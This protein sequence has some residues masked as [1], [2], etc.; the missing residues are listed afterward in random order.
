MTRTAFHSVECFKPD[1]TLLPVFLCELQKY[2]SPYSVQTQEHFM[3]LSEKNGEFTR[4]STQHQQK[5]HN[6]AE[7]ATEQGREEPAG[8]GH[9]R[10]LVYTE[11]ERV[12]AESR[13]PAARGVG[14]GRDAVSVTPRLRR[15]APGWMRL[16]ITS[17]SRAAPPAARTARGGGGSPLHRE[18]PR[19]RR[20]PRAGRLPGRRSSLGAALC[21]ALRV[22]RRGASGLHLAAA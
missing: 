22:G 20:G 21:P 3:P 5:E 2:R 10:L 17:S 4:P 9:A 6:R 8:A 15:G 19:A 16:W 18:R 11:V 7:S 14:S 12:I 13:A 1:T